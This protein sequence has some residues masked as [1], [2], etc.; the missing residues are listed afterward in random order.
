MFWC[1]CLRILT[2]GLFGTP[3][4]SNLD[5]SPTRTEVS[6]TFAIE[7]STSSGE[8]GSSDFVSP[9]SDSSCGS[10]WEVLEDIIDGF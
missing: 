9:G 1:V 2:C 4:E 10:P 3:E 7:D 6:Y 5:L 8:E